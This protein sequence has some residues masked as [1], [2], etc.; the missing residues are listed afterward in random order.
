MLAITLTLLALGAALAFFGTAGF[1]LNWSAPDHDSLRF[2][3]ILAKA[4]RRLS[5][6]GLALYALA[7]YGASGVT[8]IVLIAVGVTAA[9][10]YVTA[11]SNTIVPTGA[12]P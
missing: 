8:L 5:V 2:A 4:G 1:A 10:T 11:T 12:T 9:A 6:A 3:Q 7:H